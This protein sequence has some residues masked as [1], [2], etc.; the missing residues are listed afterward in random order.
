M[1]LIDIKRNYQAVSTKLTNTA[2]KF[3]IPSEKIKLIAV[4]KT[5]PA[6]VLEEAFNSG[7]SIFGENYVQEL[8]EKQAILKDKGILPEWHFIGH[9]Q[10]NKVKYIAEFIDTIHS[11][12]SLKLASEISKQAEKHNRNIKV[13]IQI[14][15]SGEES[16]SGCEPNQAVELAKGIISLPNISLLGMMTI[17][18]FSEDES[19]IRREFG[20]LKSSLAEVNSKLSLNLQELSMGM[21]HD[22]DIAIEEGSTMVRVGTAIFGYRDYSK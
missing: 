15:T 6:E 3:S 7:I 11:V 10:S 21:S 14:N 22:F 1:N 17:G 13:L 5:H 20:I 18:T 12:D 9:L 16:K 4:S 2:Q 19:I 8:V